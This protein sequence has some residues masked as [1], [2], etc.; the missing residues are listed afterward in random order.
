MYLLATDMSSLEK[1]LFRSS[2]HFLIEYVFNI[3]L[4]E[5]YILEIKLLSVTWLA[6]IFSQWVYSLFFLFMISFAMQKL[7]SLIRYHLLI[8]AL[9][10]FNWE[11]DLRKHCSDM[12]ENILPTFYS[13]FMVSCLI[14]RS[15]NYF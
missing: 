10:F 4:Y 11:N 13:S 8:F 7:L 2:V 14:F 9:Y 15:L 6:N 12:S 5:L 3:E 1:Y